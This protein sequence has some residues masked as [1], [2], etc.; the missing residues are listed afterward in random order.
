MTSGKYYKHI[1]KIVKSPCDIV[2]TTS[3]T[4]L[5]S[6]VVEENSLTLIC[7]EDL[8]DYF[9]KTQRGDLLIEHQ[10]DGNVRIIG[11]NASYAGAIV[12]ISVY[13]NVINPE[14]HMM[15][16]LGQDSDTVLGI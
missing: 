14:L 4:A 6:E 3:I 10:D 2:Y 7:K 11:I 13:Y 12:T 5:R 8:L 15:I 16:A 1:G 9:A